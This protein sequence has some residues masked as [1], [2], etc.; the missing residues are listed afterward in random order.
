MF[1]FPALAI[2]LIALAPYRLFLLKT[3]KAPP[4]QGCS[5]VRPL[6]D[7]ASATFAKMASPSRFGSLAKII[8]LETFGFES[9]YF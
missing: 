8:N 6:A 2:V 5:P 3:A 7:V 1:V 9:F 4:S